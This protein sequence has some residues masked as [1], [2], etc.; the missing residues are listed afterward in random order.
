MSNQ[1]ARTNEAF[2]LAR[3][4]GAQPLK[5]TELERVRSILKNK[6]GATIW[7]TLLQLRLLPTSKPFFANYYDRHLHN[8]LL[9]DLRGSLCVGNQHALNEAKRLNLFRARGNA[10]PEFLEANRRDFDRLL[11]AF[12]AEANRKILDLISIRDFVKQRGYAVA[13][14]VLAFDT[15]EQYQAAEERKRI[16]LKAERD[17]AEAKRHKTEREARREVALKAR[18]HGMASLSAQDV[19][20]ILKEVC[21][22]GVIQNQSA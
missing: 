4:S 3:K 20:I 16:A 9:A 11:A 8:N 17:K 6:D 15:F 21:I 5:S 10:D 2:R 12:R 1:Q 19:V 14:A 18:N 7:E 22:A 13:I